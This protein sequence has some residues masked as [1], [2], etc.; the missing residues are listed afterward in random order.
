MSARPRWSYVQAR[1]QARYGERLQEADWRVLEAALSIDQYIERAR[2]TSLRRVAERLNARLSSHAIERVLREEWRGT[3][4]EVAAWL[5]SPWRAAVQ[6]TAPLG[7]LPL[8]DGLL[9][10]DLAD[11]MR[12]DAVFAPLADA[13]RQ[14]R[15]AALAKSPLAPLAASAESETTPAG[16]WFKHWRALWP[17]APAGDTRP[18]LDLAAALEDHAARLGAA[19]PQDSSARHRR[20]LA[21]SLTRL[22]RRHSASPAAVFSYLALVALDLERLRGGLLRRRLFESGRAKDAA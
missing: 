7:E 16:R 15:L 19:G 3:V 5:P 21:Q 10:G 12:D 20:D 9:R 18:L 13:D 4:A 1:L 11:W 17:R 8:I 6:W 22:F 14:R 2:A